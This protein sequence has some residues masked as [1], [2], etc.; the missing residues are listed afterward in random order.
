[1]AAAALTLT[2]GSDWMI[3]AWQTLA[4]RC[5][6]RYSEKTANVDWWPGRKKVKEMKSRDICSHCGR[7]SSPLRFASSHKAWTHSPHQNRMIARVKRSSEARKIGESKHFPLFEGSGLG[8][9]CFPRHHP[10]LQLAADAAH[11]IR[12][13]RITIGGRGHRPPL[14][15]G[16]R[17]SIL[18]LPIRLFTRPITVRL[19]G[20]RQKEHGWL[21][22][23][24]CFLMARYDG[25][26]TRNGSGDVGL[27]VSLLVLSSGFEAREPR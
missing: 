22:E 7:V 17:C 13:R 9:P 24:L 16:F 15:V 2:V 26:T 19:V 12:G 6:S 27:N 21:A 1:M 14:L 3:K 5:F 18:V 25:A 23:R 11:Q 10:P 20:V 8:W 4:N